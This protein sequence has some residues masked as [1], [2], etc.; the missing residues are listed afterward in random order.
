MDVAWEGFGIHTQSFVK[1][2]SMVFLKREVNGQGEI[3]FVTML[4]R[5]LLRKF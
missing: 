4:E 3:Y 2:E 1:A 5:L